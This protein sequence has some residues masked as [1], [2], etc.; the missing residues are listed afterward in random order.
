VRDTNDTISDFVHG[1]DKI[2][3]DALGFNAPVNASA[4]SAAHD[5]IWSVQGGNTVILG[6]TDGDLT[7][8]EFMITLT[9]V[10]SLDAGDFVI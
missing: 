8:A 7:T 4:F 5:L 6:D 3:V 9:G 2:D 10:I 1:I